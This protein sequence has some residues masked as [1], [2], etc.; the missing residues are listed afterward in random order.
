MTIYPCNMFFCICSL[1]TYSSIRKMY[2]DTCV[3]VG[4][5]VCVCVA[6]AGVWPPTTHKYLYHPRPIEGAPSDIT[7]IPLRPR[8][9]PNDRSGFPRTPRELPGDA[10]DPPRHAQRSSENPLGIPGDLQGHRGDPPESS[11][12]HLGSPRDRRRAPG[13]ASRTKRNQILVE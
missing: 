2:I 13:G 10:R 4:V 8:G 1:Y 6:A 7:G 3:G 11:R 12:L 5:C 9:A